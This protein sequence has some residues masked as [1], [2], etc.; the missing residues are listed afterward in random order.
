MVGVTGAGRSTLAG[1]VG[2]R[3]GDPRFA[4]PTTHLFARP[5]GTEAWLTPL[6]DCSVP[7]AAYASWSRER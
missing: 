7:R 6:D 4:L 3:L 2:E 1:G 5:D